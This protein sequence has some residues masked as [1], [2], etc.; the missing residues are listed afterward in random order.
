MRPFPWKWRVCNEQA[1]KPI[2]VDYSAEMEHDGRLYTF[3][4]PNLEI[5][6][7]EA[8][9]S[10]VLPKKAFA[11]V[12]DRL[13]SEA[14]L[15]TPM[16]IRENRKRLGLTQEQLANCLRVA[17]ETVS[18]WETGGQIQQ[19]AMNDFMRAFF[20]VPELRTYLALIRGCAP[21]PCTPAPETYPV[22]HGAAT[23]TTVVISAPVINTPASD[24]YEP[25]LAAAP[26]A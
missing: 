13:R 18:R 22:V 2:E 16:Q 3:T 26:A 17:K 20:D 23:N 9:R 5:L 15:L 7:C 12:I 21:V 6:E 25:T 8:C 19:R 4:V 1:L 10:R 11:A 14:G 24:Y